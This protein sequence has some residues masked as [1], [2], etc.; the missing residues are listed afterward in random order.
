M[1]NLFLQET[2]YTDDYPSS[3]ANVMFDVNLLGSYYIDGGD[4]NDNIKTY[5]KTIN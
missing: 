5:I 3:V 2:Y 1:K 4:K